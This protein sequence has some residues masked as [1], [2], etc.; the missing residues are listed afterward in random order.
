MELESNLSAFRRSPEAHAESGCGVASVVGQAAPI[1][2][3][4]LSAFGTRFATQRPEYA[5]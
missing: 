5:G 1:P 4:T 3:Q 2:P